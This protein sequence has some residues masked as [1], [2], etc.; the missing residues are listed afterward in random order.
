MQG[1]A[2][3]KTRKKGTGNIRRYANGVWQSSFAHHG[4]RFFM[5]AVSRDEAEKKLNCALQFAKSSA[6]DGTKE[7]LDQHLKEMGYPSGL[8]R[9]EPE[10]ISSHNIKQNSE[11]SWRV[12]LMI[13]G[14]QYR[15][16]AVSKEEAE[17][18]FT[19]FQAATEKGEF[20]FTQESL[21]KILKDSGFPAGRFCAP[22]SPV[23]KKE[24]HGPFQNGVRYR[25][26][27]FWEARYAFQGKIESIY[28]PTEKE[29]QKRLR[30]VLVAIDNGTFIGK[31][32][33]TFCGYLMSWLEHAAK[34][35]LRPNTEKKYRMYIQAH[36]LPYFGE[37]K[38]QSITAVSLQEFFDLKSH[39]GRADGKEGGLSHKT[40][41]D[42]RNMLKK[43][44]N[45]AVNPLKLLQ[46][47][48]AREVELKF[49]RP[50]PVSL[51]TAEQEKVLIERGM[52]SDSPIG[53]AVVI[54]LR[55]GMRR[56][57]LLGLQLGQ[58][59]S[60]GS[61]F[62]V[63]KS[64]CR[65]EHPNPQ[66]APDYTRIDVWAKK[67]N[68]TG[69]YLGPPK[70][71]SS[72]RTF[73]VGTQ[74]KECVGKLIAYQERLLGYSISQCPYQG[75]ENFLLVSPLL[76]PYDL[77]TFDA[78]FKSFLKECGI[79]GVGVHATRHSFITNMVQ[80][81]PEEL[82][83]ISEIVGHS[84]KATTLGYSHGSDQR[85]QNLMDSF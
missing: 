47:N 45:Y 25:R 36:L 2:G 73:P 31:N 15:I 9:T 12:T 71:E 60:N 26:E 41:T 28:A 20:S 68:K 42:L 37:A 66:Q 8:S 52:K 5:Q 3:T 30:A 38:L 76:R 6:F 82:P 1:T 44:L 77:K 57:E 33:E 11:N 84:D 64:L 35:S 51:I 78:H 4:K 59:I 62:R 72:I 32:K 58:I 46:H 80:K 49:H 85:K 70:T 39:S 43:S 75:A 69:L 48:P 81:F 83:S 14:R 19:A 65:M 24:K 16:S 23:E 21:D 17:R 22:R 50:K 54:L 61:C 56:G 53:W 63:E 27:G 74:V 55:T 10:I 40:L 67:K 29:A 34:T 7:A 79:T 13:Q 18:K